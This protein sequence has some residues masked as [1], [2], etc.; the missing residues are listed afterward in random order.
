MDRPTLGANRREG[1][2]GRGGVRGN[3]GNIGVHSL[4]PEPTPSGQT[5]RS[6]PP[7]H[8]PD[9]AVARAVL[10]PR[11]AQVGAG[12][13]HRPGGLGSHGSDNGHAPAAVLGLGARGLRP[14]PGP[15]VRLRLRGPSDPPARPGSKVKLSRTRQGSQPHRGFARA[16]SPG[17]RRSGED[18]RRPGPVE[19]ERDR[20]REEARGEPED[21]VQPAEGRT[22]WVKGSIYS[23]R[24][25]RRE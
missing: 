1:C 21:G 13:V 20:G 5:A 4:E 17:N 8:V 16:G 3:P 11:S 24:L 10:Q 25:F 15:E 9:C 18:L 7:V 6:D 19:G 22:I 2:C 23:V 12:R 14:A